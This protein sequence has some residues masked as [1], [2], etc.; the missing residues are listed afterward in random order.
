MASI[1]P[2]GRPKKVR[3]AARRVTVSPDFALAQYLALGEK[4]SIRALHRK[5]EAEG[6]KIGYRH[7]QQWS[8]ANNWV[9]IS[10][11]FDR[12]HVEAADLGIRQARLGRGL[13]AVAQVG[14]DRLLRETP[15]T[16]DIRALSAAAKAG[17]DIERT[18]V[19]EA[20][21]E[22]STARY[23]EVAVAF[24]R[25][26]VQVVADLPDDVRERITHRFAVGVNA[27]RDNWVE[28]DKGDARRTDVPL[29]AAPAEIAQAEQK[30]VI[31]V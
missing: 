29:L 28:P 18:A 31:D 4:R 9:E 19:G 14:V 26:F 7:L 30:E 24:L 3:N 6:E 13:Q 17:V 16:G 27:V 5:L 10:E 15:I 8:K 20:H 1:R 12:E 2:P 23:N 25:V 21:S 22:D 11:G